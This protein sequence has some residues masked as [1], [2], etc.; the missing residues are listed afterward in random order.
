ME[1]L[2]LWWGLVNLLPVYPLD[3]GQIAMEFFR[4]KW[5]YDGAVRTHSFCIYVAGMAALGFIAYPLIL[6]EQ[7]EIQ[8]YPACCAA[9][10]C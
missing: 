10:P 5:P 7:R 8:W 1:Y 4:S 2:N 6:G 3:G 9:F